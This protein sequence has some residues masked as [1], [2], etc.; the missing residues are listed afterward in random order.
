MP[1]TP[2]GALTRGTIR[3]HLTSQT[4]ISKSMHK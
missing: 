1:K 3:F 4:F 2:L